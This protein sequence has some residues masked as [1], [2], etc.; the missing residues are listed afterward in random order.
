MS[1]AKN[2][3]YREASN[4]GPLLLFLHGAG[5]DYSFWSNLNRYFVYKN[6][7]T[8]SI[9]LPGHGHNNDK[10]LTSIEAMANYVVTLIKKL[11]HKKIVPIGHSM[12]SLI[13][14]SLAA[15]N[16]ID[17]EKIILIGTSLPM[18][19]SDFLLEQS[20][21]DQPKAINNMIN[22]GLP[23]VAKLNGGHITG[24]NL[25]NYFSN[26][27]NNIQKGVLYKDLNA[28]N[29]FLLKEKVINQ[30]NMPVLIIAGDKDL[31]TPTKSSIYLK[32]K[33]PN[34]MLEILNESI[35]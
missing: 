3:I 16:K 30:I 24:V 19:V 25:P 13:C 5:C 31:M 2:F 26:L 4:N 18:K 23:T 7:S 10:P 14:L 11:K 6:F 21:K 8:L 17:I 34:A 9:S 28:C 29:N 22:W 32:N 1:Y 35:P 12:G 20:K 33:L 15:E 27:M